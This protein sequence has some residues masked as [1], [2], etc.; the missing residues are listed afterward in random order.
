MTQLLVRPILRMFLR[1]HTVRVI[2]LALLYSFVIGV[3]IT[4]AYL[5]RF[6]FNLP[7]W[8][9]DNVFNTCAIVICVQL[10]SMFAFR[11]FDGLLSYFSTPDLKRL[12]L[13]CACAVAILGA[14]RFSLGVDYAPPRGVLLTYYFL[15]VIALSSLRLTFRSLRRIEAGASALNRVKARRIGIVGAGDCG[16]TLAKDLLKKPWLALKPVAFFDDRRDSLC[17]VHGIRLAGRPERIPHFRRTLDLDEI[18]IAMPSAPAKR[19]RELLKLCHEAGLP[20]RTVPSVDQLATGE[21]SVTSLREIEIHDLLGRTPVEIRGEAVLDEIEGHTVVVT[22][23]GGSIGSELCRQILTYRPAILV[24]VERSEPQLFVIEQELNAK[25]G[26]AEVVPVVADITQENRMREVFR[27]FR[28][29]I[30]F[31]AAAHKH[32]PM[33]EMQPGEAIRNNVFGTAL[34]ADLAIEHGVERFIHISTDKAVNPTNVMGATKR[35]AE[36]YLQSLG[37]RP[38]HTKFMAVRF[39]NVLGSSGSVVPTFKRQIAEGGP[40]TVTHPEVTRFFMTIPEAVSLV[41]QSSAFGKGGDIFVLDMGKPVRILDLAL[42]VIELSGLKPYEDIEIRFTGLRPGEKLYEELSHGGER[43]TAT[44]HEKIARL[45]TTPM[46]HSYVV[47]FLEELTTVLAEGDS[48]PASLKELLARMLPE[49]QP[50]IAG[51]P[52][53]ERQE[54]TKERRTM[55]L[56]GAAFAGPSATV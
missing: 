49:Y 25:R 31:H 12:M 5:L 39:G 26:A 24:L 3:C 54:A 55:E 29:E 20:C 32:V 30:I 46:H 10:L 2:S 15:S 8:L 34:L 43:V 51:A 23:A 11:Q 35:L 19:I 56:A 40:V 45:I 9:R 38:S 22:G 42:Q 7:G 1:T 48:D 13:A 4:L 6:D 36:M 14:L 52:V 28:P 41:L 18:I 50:F 37:T 44:A 27:R 17:S 16:A 53:P 47:A 21:V 33:M